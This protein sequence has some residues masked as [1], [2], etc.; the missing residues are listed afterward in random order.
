MTSRR[1]LLLRAVGAFL[2]LPGVVAF[3]VPLLLAT[4]AL[5]QG[6]FH[7]LALV[8]LVLGGALL[9]WCAR[10]FFTEGRGTLAPWAP[11]RQ[12]VTGGPYA[13]SRNP[14]YIAV[15]LILVGWVLAFRST[16]LV[17]YALAVLVAFHLRVRLHEEPRLSATFHDTWRRYSGRVP[18]WIFR[19]RRHAVSA[20]VAVVA[21][22]VFAGL[23]FEAYA[24]AAGAR[25]FPAPG[26]MVDVGGRRLHLVC[27]GEGTP[28]VLFEPSGFSNA[29]S[30]EQARGRIATRTRVCSY[31]RMGTGW[32]DPG[33]PII[34]VGDLV[35]D[36]AVLQDRAPLGSPL[37]IVA[38]SIG[39]LTAETLA[40]R[41]PERVAALVFLDAAN[42]GLAASK[43]GARVGVATAAACAAAASAHLG[44]MR[45]LDPFGIGPGTSEGARRSAAVTYNARTWGSVCGFM[46]GA[47][48]TVTELEKLPPLPGDVPLVVL[49]ASTER[50]HVPGFTW[51][52]GELRAQ[53]IPSHQHL[54][55]ASSRGRWALIP[56][57]GHLLAGDKPDL[58]ADTVLELLEHLDATGSSVPE[59]ALSIPSGRDYNAPAGG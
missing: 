25:E 30:Y 53:R 23:V 9:V 24:D 50:D 14:M 55:K 51:L 39:G 8:P 57:S 38:S 43:S 46:R 5:R 48:R 32:S 40:R 47:G 56:D 41:H 54:A 42:S 45:L 59:G 6:R 18:R 19:R 16:T 37:V 34:S 44:L 22:L 20:T 1:L 13:Y 11:P 21:G 33:P 3:L 31:D 26:L 35:N 15:G 4:P 28:T 10:Q 2:A 58:V 27:I 52:A 49:S 7:L 29:L 12:L 36:L 17:V